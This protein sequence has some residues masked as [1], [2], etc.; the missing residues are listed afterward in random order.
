MQF[1]NM[2]NYDYSVA[3]LFAFTTIIFGIVGMLVGIVI[4]FEM[5][6]PEL[7]N[8]VGEYGTFGRLRS[9]H[10]D[11]IIF[12]FLGS[13][14]FSAWYYIG[15]RVLKVSMTESLF[16]MALGRIHFLLYLLI[17]VAIMVSRL[18]GFISPK[19]YAEFEWPIDIGIIAMWII[20][21]M[22]IFGLIGIRR[23]KTL[24]ISIWYYIATFFGVAMMYPLGNMAVPTYFIAGLGDWW[25]S[26]SMYAGGNDA[27]IQQ[28]YEHNAVVSVFMAPITAMIYYFLP[29]ESGQPIFSYKLSLLGFWGLMFV[30]FWTGGYHLLYSTAP[31]WIQIMG[32]IFSV[33][34]ILPL[35]GNAINMFLT[36]KGEWQRLKENLLIK[37]MIIALIFYMLLILQGSIQTI[38]S[39]NALVH[40][41]D[42]I[43]GCV[44]SGALG[45][46]G[47]MIVVA[48]LHMAPRV[49]KKELY[50]KKL[51]QAQFWIQTIGTVLYLS[52]TWIVG[53]TQG[54]MSRATDQHGNLVYSFIDIVNELHFYYIIRGVGG[55][56]YLIG[57]IIFAY[58]LY[59]TT[60]VGRELEE[61]PQSTSPVAA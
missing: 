26:V 55:L 50:S 29:K 23:E 59:K 21:G 36:I 16:L 17:V 40:F 54:M 15:Q 8:L 13:G 39:V 4:A 52:S 2:I 27:M 10:I 61:E 7:N 1:S 49:F 53:I 14:I 20:W 58:N 38:K 33:V 46:V 22:S 43:P 57:F 18:L 5:A 35:W 28:W 60:T 3:K 31:D 6:Y 30:Y 9:L 44:Y 47:F 48:L 41:I 42:W 56:L 25:H 34:L 11:L 24:H 51:M 45:W 32:S 19:G 37:F 12:G